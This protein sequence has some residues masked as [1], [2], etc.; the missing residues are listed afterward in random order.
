MKY[1]PD[2]DGLRAIAVLLVL[3]FHL[4]VTGFSAGWLGVDVFFILSG[5]LVTSIISVKIGQE[6]FSFK[7]FYIR[8][9]RRLF[10]ALFATV[11]L[12]FIAGAFILV[13]ADFQALSKSA[14]GAVFSISNM[15]FWSEAGY[16]DQASHLKPLLHTWSLSVEEQFYLVW[17]ALIFLCG[18]TRSKKTLLILAGLGILSYLAG[19]AFR[20]SIS[21]VFYIFVF[22]IFEF[23]AG[24]VLGLYMLSENKV[25]L[26]KYK[27]RQ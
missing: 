6:T 7:D 11:F 24:G 12:T 15:V 22:R 18:G 8:R 14:L 10:P 13:P 5:F 1:R 21:A 19:I 16:W 20:D 26:Q 23:A 27:P 4:D 2:I 25:S 3:F 17:P 9:I